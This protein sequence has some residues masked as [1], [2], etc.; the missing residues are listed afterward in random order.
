[1]QDETTEDSTVTAINSGLHPFMGGKT[2]SISGYCDPAFQAVADVFE[3]NLMNRGDAGD[4]GASCA[5]TLDG[6]TVVDL[7][8]GFADVESHRAWDEDT[9]CCC[10]SVSKTIGAVLTLRMIDQ[11]LLDLDE[12]VAK[13]WP[14]FGAN[15]KDH[16]LVRHLLDHTAGLSYL[17]ADLQAGDTN[18]WDVMIRAIEESA[19]NWEAGSKLGY[20]NMTQGYLLAGLCAKVNGG[21]R[22]AQ[23]LKEE[24]ASP[25]NLDWHFSVSDENLKRVAT[26]Y[27]TDPALFS[28]I[29]EKDPTTTFAKSMKGRDP[30]ETYNSS[31]W[32][33][34]ENGAGTGHT[35]ARAMAKLYGALARGGSLDG[36]TV[37]SDAAMHLASSESVREPCA[38]NGFEM[39]FSQGFEMH[40]PPVTP[41]GRC[42]RSFGYI[43]A[44]GTFAFAD[45]DAKLGFGYSHNLMH[46]GIGP[47]S[48]GL[49]LV[50]AAINS[51]YA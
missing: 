28:R 3:V 50:D 12:P 14:A 26:V 8:G 38:V 41:M 37:L 22:L 5:V 39:R 27:Q 47:G 49:P 9:L 43:G 40:C 6:E 17:D 15:G 46:T 7:W 51:A 34:A 29:I 21:R 2:P 44:G 4:V 48:C 45:P 30:N 20:L 18:K 42:D 23:F 16:I 32:H 33:K 13:Y 35:N 19:P 31:Q 11:G 10:W 24:L 1:M 25:L 36:F